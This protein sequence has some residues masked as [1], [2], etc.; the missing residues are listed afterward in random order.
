MDTS[1]LGIKLDRQ[2]RDR[3]RALGQR[4]DRATHWIINKAIDEYLAR[5]EQRER[6]RMEDA[7]RWEQYQTTGMA[8]PNDQVMAWLDD[9]GAGKRTSW[10]T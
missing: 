1:T 5:E 8:V 3:L 4:K 10:R 6:A 2:T 9:L 7:Q